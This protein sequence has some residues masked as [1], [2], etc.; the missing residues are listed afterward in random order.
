VSNPPRLLVQ[1]YIISVVL[2]FHAGVRL[3]LLGSLITTILAATIILNALYKVFPMNAGMAGLSLI[4]S[5]TIVNNLN[6]FLNALSETEQE[7]VSVERVIEYCDLPNEFGEYLSVESKP[8][9]DKSCGLCC[10]WPDRSGTSKERSGAYSALQSGEHVMEAGTYTYDGISELDA[11]IGRNDDSQHGDRSLWSTSA[12]LGA[13]GGSSIAYRFLSRTQEGMEL[14]HVSMS[15]AAPLDNRSSFSQ[16]ASVDCLRDITI[17]IAPGSR[18]AVVGRTGSGK[19]SLLRMLLRINDYHAGTVKLSGVELRSIPKQRLRTKLSVI[20][21]KPL[22][23]SGTIRFNLDPVGEYST[24]DLCAALDM[25]KIS[26]TLVKNT[27]GGV[28]ERRSEAVHSMER[29]TEITLRSSSSFLLRAPPAA[30]EVVNVE[31]L[32]LLDFVIEDGGANLS[33]GQQQ[34]L[35]LARAI[36]R[37][38]DLILVDEATAAVDSHTEALL[39]ASLAQYVEATGASM[40]MVCH[41]LGGVNRVCNK[42]SS[43]HLVA[44]WY[45]TLRTSLFVCVTQILTMDDGRIVSYE[46]I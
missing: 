15:Y 23:F 4:Y 42:V 2:W 12:S 45:V 27:A 7:M 5:F 26:Q 1:S 6:G 43:L 44:I 34:L 19:S 30:D 33:V 37:R 40:L 22:L 38:S 13:R 36:L 3:Q 39:Y 21:Q 20:P 24:E 32:P 46:D 9:T 31:C 14:E 16:P 18:V 11:S 10:R 41:K 8:R 25:C 17:T 29:F 28:A 35:C